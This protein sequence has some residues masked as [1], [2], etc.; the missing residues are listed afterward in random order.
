M[1]LLDRWGR[2]AAG[3]QPA[4]DEP[5][6]R[7]PL[8]AAGMRVN[9]TSPQLVHTRRHEWQTAAWDY[10]D[11]V[12]EL[13]FA[14]DFVTSALGRLRVFPAENR[15]RG[16]QPV[17][18]A[19][20]AIPAEVTAAPAVTE[21]TRQAAAA[22]VARLDLDRHG[23]NLLSRMGENLEFAGE[24]FL[25]GEPGDEGEQWTIRSV[26]EV[27]ITQGG[28]RLI[29][30]GQGPVA[31]R[32][33]R[34]EECEL[35][36]LWN[37]HPRYYDWPDAATA[38]LLGTLEG[39]VLLARRGR[40]HD[41]SRISSG[42]ALFIPD[43]LSLSRAGDA[44]DVDEDG[45][46][47]LAGL[48]EAML[49]PIRDESD[50]S[51]VVPIL[52]RGPGML[53]DT[54]TANVIGTVDLHGEDPKDLDDR[55]ENLVQRFARGINLPP[56]IVK[57][58]GDTNHWCVDEQTE[59]LT[60][61]G[62]MTQ[63]R[64]NIGDT[65]LTL[66]HDTGL[67]E[68]QPV[69]DIYR[70]DVV[71]E[72]MIGMETRGHSSLTTPDHR[73]AVISQRGG[74]N[75]NVDG[76]IVDGRHERREWTTS[77]TMRHADNIPTCAP[78][79]D[80]P[81]TAKYDDDLV[82]LVGWYWTEGSV[83]GQAVCIAQSHTANPERVDRIRASLTRL[84]GP[85]SESLRGGDTPRWREHIQSNRTSHGGPITVFYLSRAASEPLRAA[86]PDKIVSREFVRAL[87]SAQLELFIDVSAQGD[88]WHYRSGDR[89][90]MWQRD[91]AAL[92]G[93]ELALILSGRAV[94][95]GM[96]SD[97]HWVS[98]HRRARVNPKAA[99]SKRTG[100]TAT[101]GP[102][103]YTGVVWCPTT[104][105]HTWFARRR[106]TTYFTGNTGAMVDATMVKSHIE[107]RA[108]RMVDALT[109]AY[110]RPALKA[111]GV[112]LEQRNR[113][114]LW[115]DSSELVQ[116]P[117]RDQATKDGHEAGVLSDASMRRELGFTEDDAPSNLEML[118]RA[119]DRERLSPASVPI[120]V[121]LLAGQ[122][123][124]E[125]DISRILG[126]IHPKTID[127]TPTGPPD[128]PGGATPAPP[129]PPKAIAAAAKGPRDDP[130]GPSVAGVALMAADTGRVLMLQRGLDD[131]QDPAAG[132]WEFPGGHIEDGDETSLH[133]GMREWAEEVG[134]PFPDGGAVLH[135]WTSPDGVYQGHVIVI[136]E[137]KA[138]D[139]AGKRVTKNPDDDYS[140]QAAWWEP[141]HAAKNPALRRECRKTPW[142]ALK[143]AV[144][145]Y[146][147]PLTAAVPARYRVDEEACRKLAEIDR[148]LTDRLIAHAE[149]TIGRAVE[150]AANR[151][152]GR[153]QKDP[154]LAASFPKGCDPVTVCAAAGRTVQG[155][156]TDVELVDGAVEDFGRRFLRE[157]THA[158]RQA[159]AVV[160]GMVGK[161]AAAPVEDAI[162]GRAGR[163]WAWLRGRLERH[164]TDVLYGDAPRDAITGEAPDVEASPV[165]TS[166]VRGA[167]TIV[168]GQDETEPGIDD[169]GRTV[170]APGQAPA[171]QTG[172]GTGQTVADAITVG[173]GE[174]LGW[175]W[176]YYGP[177]R[178]SPFLPHRALDGRR[179]DGF[180]D[181]ALATGADAWLGP[182]FH[183]G[184]HPGC[185][186][187]IE[188]V[189][190]T[191]TTSE[192]RDE[193]TLE[194]TPAMR[195]TRLLAE[196]DDLHPGR[197][198]LPD[199]RTHAQRDRD[200][201]AEL[202]RLRREH[203]TNRELR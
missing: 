20:D 121:K 181:P 71:D 132:A 65:V 73:W 56:E 140:E 143:R 153:A 124:T 111:M 59:V 87:T 171:P 26:S 108:E 100:G 180:D 169:T 94:T 144:K 175:I 45:D 47:F 5:V 29:E 193:L 35:L 96:S 173:G 33:L 93:Y 166:I 201:A 128:S 186:C 74:R 84:Y 191:P 115:F 98:P 150:K 109:A 86:A 34:P 32:E 28:A 15:P 81:V 76:E 16:Q 7:R 72:P 134:Q 75:R 107:P 95:R 156:V 78:N 184:D 162:V 139:L 52:I 136:P 54:P 60:A 123:P 38:S 190:A 24:C 89:L 155:D 82:E 50:P 125:R 164:I 90:D 158:A 70:A 129:K 101:V 14:G 62:W 172:P 48:T 68:W 194:E 119:V 6:R 79:T 64:L 91:P 179:F 17:P 43:E 51:A 157:V 27:Q 120:L 83:R 152:R 145:T 46:P 192:L 41:R 97:G 31:T 58:I 176:G 200:T 99:A 92:E 114:C 39:M 23:S 18:L 53:G 67:S 10:R 12:P 118:R 4:P 146:R 13:R 147:S 149:A 2:I 137:E 88:G 151:V 110:F 189:W 196:D 126:E 1:G 197:G 130:Q 63:E 174:K 55:Y 160:A 106:G 202:D 177:P 133:G 185:L 40:A 122:M 141:D 21:A 25:L 3:P 178:R 42:K 66:N 195:D 80:L 77:Q 165:P 102:E 113:V 103:A 116:N 198:T 61:Q 168:G 183:P 127:A 36:R 159:A 203:I 11:E 167:L 104:D 112:P 57:G 19:H 161:K 148:A 49:A 37:P 117:N 170:V 135:T 9:L 163:A 131:E 22:A 199:G 138:L 30:P 188:M 187:S 44:E 85:A 182:Y 105:N 154:L 8:T 69:R 142:S